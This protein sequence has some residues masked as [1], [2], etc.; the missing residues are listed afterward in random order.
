M[1]DVHPPHHSPNT[2]RDF[3]IHIA[4]IVVGLLIAIGLEQTVEFFHHRHE[5]KQAREE[6]RV[7]VETNRRVTAQQLALVHKAQAELHADMTLLLAHRATGKPVNGA[8][9]FDWSFRRTQNAAWEANKQVGALNLL[10]H[11]ELH[12]YSYVFT[13]CAVVMDSAEKWQTKIETAKAI[14]TRAPDGQLS[15][16]DTAELLTAISDAQGNLAR[17]ERLITFAQGALSSYDYER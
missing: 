2:W 8:L 10:P 6:L 1:L 12:F 5:L 11:S 15:Q 9:G 3:F 4:T 14:A 13:V 16:Q 17:T 7:E